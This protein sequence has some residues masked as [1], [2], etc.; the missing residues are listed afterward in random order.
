MKAVLL[1]SGLLMAGNLYAAS[2][3]GTIGVKLT[4]Y[5]RC[6]ID[7]TGQRTPQI[8]CG[9]RSSAQPR[10]THSRLAAD[11]QRNIADQLITIEW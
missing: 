4:I 8:D 5:S 7:G 6:Q 9:A 11:A 1:A 10:V 2:T 3:T